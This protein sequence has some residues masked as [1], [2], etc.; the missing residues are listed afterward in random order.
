MLIE[1]CV[2]DRHR[3]L[4]MTAL[5]TGLRQ[6][7]LL[8]LRWEDVDLD[9]RRLTVRH[10]LA[11]VDGRLTLLEPETSRSRRTIALPEVTLAAI[12]AHR[13]RQ[14]ME[15]LVAGHADRQRCH[16]AG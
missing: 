12:R 3:A 9:E 5:S 6:G 14:R 8:G 15:R 7:E 10:S 11:C 16:A 13:T 4:S 1:S 2:D